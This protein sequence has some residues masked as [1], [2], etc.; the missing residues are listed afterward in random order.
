MKDKA[1]QEQCEQTKTKPNKYLTIIANFL[2]N[3]PEKPIQKYARFP[4]KTKQKLPEIAAI[5]RAF[6]LPPSVFREKHGENKEKKET[7][8]APMLLWWKGRVRNEREKK[9]KYWRDVEKWRGR[10]KE[11]E[12]GKEERKMRRRVFGR[13]GNGA[14]HTKMMRLGRK[15][16]EKAE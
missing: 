1:I 4:E 3:F 11:K 10:E 9:R 7:G 14:A 6:V 15:R 13:Q 8:S 2:W 16:K 12:R 5:W